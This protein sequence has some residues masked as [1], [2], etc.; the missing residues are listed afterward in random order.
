MSQYHLHRHE[1]HYIS[2]MMSQKSRTPGCPCLKVLIG[3][4]TQCFPCRCLFCSSTTAF[5][6]PYS[7]KA[8]LLPVD[9]RKKPRNMLNTLYCVGLSGRGAS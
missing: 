2:I 4:M 1:V 7:F 8:S 9:T 6:L 5:R 3:W